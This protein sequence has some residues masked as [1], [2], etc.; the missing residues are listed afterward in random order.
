IEELRNAGEARNPGGVGQQVANGDAIPRGW[1]FRVVLRYRIVDRQLSGLRQLQN[2]RCCKLFRDGT[3]PKLGV[4][5]V[6]NV[7][8]PV[9]QPEGLSKHGYTAPGYQYRTA[10]LVAI[11]EGRDQRL[12]FGGQSGIRCRLGQH[13]VRT[14]QQRYSQQYETQLTHLFT[15]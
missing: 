10:E 6:W 15:P 5:S 2:S 14:A 8:L 12:G 13:E 7:P 9:G 4:R 11:H 1:R 3:D